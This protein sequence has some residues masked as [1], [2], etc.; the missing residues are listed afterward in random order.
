MANF[1]ILLDDAATLASVSASSDLEGLP[2]QN[3]KTSEP[4][5]VWRAVGNT[6][7][8]TMTWTNPVD[9]GA[10]VL[11]WTNLTPFNSV[12]V[13][14][15]TEAADV[16]PIDTKTVVAGKTFEPYLGAEGPGLGAD[17]Y[18]YSNWSSWFYVDTSSDLLE[19]QSPSVKSID[20]WFDG[21]R[22]A[23]KVVITIEDTSNTAS[24]QVGRV[25]VGRYYTL[26][27]NP[28]QVS[29]QIMDKSLV[30]RTES[31]GVRREKKSLHRRLST[32]FEQ[33]SEADTLVFLRLAKYGAGHLVFIS[34]FPT[35][36]SVF[37]QA[38]SFVA[39]LSE[40]PSFSHTFL[41]RTGYSLT[42][43][44]AS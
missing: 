8:L 1:R 22:V 18:V 25:L 32:S 19:E 30:S 2:A 4:T 35:T 38:H 36:T 27:R 16:L 37:Q 28:K 33:S 15:F 39:V 29:F 3:V 21:H 17:G 43:E 13:Q 41:Q 6:A 31:G 26:A 23:K 10:V 11:A 44:E 5:E 9:V 7:S 40:S 14:I 12:K 20:V 24:I 34:L 42:F